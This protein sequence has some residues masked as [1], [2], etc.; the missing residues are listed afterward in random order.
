MGDD[1]R[2]NERAAGADLPVDSLSELSRRQDLEERLEASERF[3]RTITDNVPVRLAYF[4]L[5]GRFKFVNQ[6]LCDRFGRPRERMLGRTLAEITG[7]APVEQRYRMAMQGVPQRFEYPDEVN[8]ETRY[9]L[10]QLIPDVAVDGTVHGV[11]GVG[12]DI[13][14]E[15]QARK[16][17]DRQT[18][19]LNAIIEAIPAMVAVWDP[20]LR[21]RLVNRAF[22]TWR[23]TPRESMVGRLYSEV[24]GQSDFQRSQRWINRV[25]AG[26]TLSFEKEYPGA[27][28][29]RHL[30]VNYIPLRLHDGSMAGF[31]AVAQDITSHREENLRLSLLSQ[32]DPLTGLLNRAGF[33]DFLTERELHGE[34]TSLAVLFIDLDHFKAINDAH[35]HATGDEVLRELAVRLL[36]LVRPTDAVAR[37]GGD[38]F[39]IAVAGLPDR[40]AAAE[41]AEKVVQTASRPIRLGQLT[42]NVGASV[43]VALS[44]GPGGGWKKLIA[45]AD[46]MAYEA[47]AAGRGQYR[48]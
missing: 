11:F 45:R 4:D 48:L 20:N 15:V 17:L 41:L 18:A 6:V 30:T 25:L 32:R 46:A 10:T 26:E 27:L 34:S 13:S 2:D 44:S 24:M 9:I 31:I 35:G 33:H 5:N 21:C 14:R 43:G 1:G 22:E 40:E 8:G 38:E 37:L 47:K 7:P 23:D 39:A 12:V 29:T 42:L 28:Q 3:V 36:C 19:T 16:E